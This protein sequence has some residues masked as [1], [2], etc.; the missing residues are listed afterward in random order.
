MKEKT[1][2]KKVYQIGL[3]LL[4][5]MFAVV[6]FAPPTVKIHISNL[7]DR[8]KGS[9]SD[10]NIGELR[11]QVKTATDFCQADS[12]KLL[13]DFER[14]LPGKLTPD[15][16]RAR[17]NI[18]EVVSELGQFKVCVKLCYKAA[19][20]KLKD[21]ND[22][23]EAY[24]SVMDEPV[25]QPCLH[26]K[27]VADNALKALEL[28]LRERQMQYAVELA[29]ACRDRA[30]SAPSPS[31]QQ[32]EKTI[33]DFSVSTQEYN[34]AQFFAAV[35]IVFE[36]IFIRET[37]KYLVKLFAKP[38]ARIC[39]SLSAATISSLAD[40]PLPFGEIISGVFIIGGLAWTA[41]DIYDVTCIM[42]RRLKEE[43]R[44]GLDTTEKD[45]TEETLAQARKLCEAYQK[46]L[47]QINQQLCE[48]LQE[49]SL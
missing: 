34:R 19:K 14:D 1:K 30:S 13:A 25:T 4:L 37:C 48:Q 12:Q 39:S 17:R 42:P 26:A 32:I 24:Q 44:T 36:I 15:F 9:G 20:D 49:E 31:I 8:L 46:N 2:M 16:D 7:W 45:L 40:G 38:A 23:Q 21:T 18:P 5:A 43:L 27:E 47:E 11:E 6:Y 29:A 10:A 22:F 35:G 3:I 41:Y 33:G 28:R